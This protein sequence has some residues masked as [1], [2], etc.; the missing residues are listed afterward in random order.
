M[1]NSKRWI[2]SIDRLEALFHRESGCVEVA[3][4]HNSCLTRSLLDL[5]TC[6][7]KPSDPWKHFWWHRD[8]HA[9]DAYPT[10]TD[11]QEKPRVIARLRERFPSWE[12]FAAYCVA[13]IE[14]NGCLIIKSHADAD[15]C[16]ALAPIF[17][18]VD[19]KAPLTLAL[20]AATRL[21]TLR[22]D[23]PISVQ[24]PNLTHVSGFVY[25]H[26]NASVIAPSLQRVDDSFWLRRASR[27][28]AAALT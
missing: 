8:A 5:G 28:D 6:P 2:D 9:P 21:S 18:A 23:G 27:F 10:L 11:P 20:P 1:D 7:P 4:P 19:C 3:D 22:L 24:L 15:A 16:S 26:Q 25:L 14:G 12:A 17:V 13:R